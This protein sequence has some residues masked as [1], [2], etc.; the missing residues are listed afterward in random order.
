MTLSRYCAP[1][2]TSDSL[3][4]SA[5]LNTLDCATLGWG[6]GDLACIKPVVTREATGRDARLTHL[7]R[8]IVLRGGPGWRTLKLTVSPIQP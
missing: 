8:L 1:P 7:A 3:V 4:D 2:L 6:S 5:P